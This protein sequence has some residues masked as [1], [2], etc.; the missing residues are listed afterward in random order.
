MQNK[1]ALIILLAVSFIISLTVAAVDARGGCDIKST[2]SPGPCVLNL[3]AST[4]T[5]ASAA[6]VNY[7]V[8]IMSVVI[9]NGS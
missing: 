2:G 9:D 4:T 6:L 7:N 1:K 5:V 3:G 8:H